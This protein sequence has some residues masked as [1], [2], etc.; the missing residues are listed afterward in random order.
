MDKNCFRILTLIGTLTIMSCL[1]FYVPLGSI[2]I[3]EL[4]ILG[5]IEK[6]SLFIT[7]VTKVLYGLGN[8]TNELIPKIKAPEA[9]D[10]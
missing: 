9:R 10:L 6:K 4:Y 8:I 3:L 7:S 1:N 2:Y 5:D